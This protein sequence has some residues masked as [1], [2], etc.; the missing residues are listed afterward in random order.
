MASDSSAPLAPGETPVTEDIL[1]LIGPI[2]IGALFSWLLYGVSC[3]QLY[4][5]HVSTYN[6][7]TWIQ[8]S[9]YIIFVMDSLQTVV[10]AFMGWGYLCSGWGHMSALT[11]PGWTFVAIPMISS[12][13][14]AWVQIFYAWR[15]HILKRWR[16]IPAVIVLLALTQC[17][18]GLSTAIGVI[19]FT[20][21][22]QIHVLEANIDVWL[23]GSAAVDT[24]ISVSMVYLLYSARRNP[25]VSA[26]GEKTVNRLIRLSVETGIATTTT[27]VLELGMFFWTPNA[28]FYV[29]LSLI[30]CKVY[31]NALMTSL[32]SRALAS[33]SR[34]FFGA[35]TSLGSSY[36]TRATLIHPT[37][38][39]ETITIPPAVVHVASH[40]EVFRSFN[41]EFKRVQSYEVQKAQDCEMGSLRDQT[42]MQGT[43]GRPHTAPSTDATPAS[44]SRTVLVNATPAGE[45]LGERPSEHIIGALHLRGAHSDRPRVKWDEGVIDNEGMEK[46]KSKICCIY[47]KPKQ[48]D[49]S[50]DESSSDEDDSD[51]DLSGARPSRAL[52]DSDDDRNAYESIP[53]QKKGKERA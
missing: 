19:P 46:K 3:V 30:L 41:N 21:V 35:E 40:T 9:V 52:D 4:L 53:H 18:A 26:R 36:G 48:F 45:R 37:R 14:A 23:A 22:S 51:S 28:N 13:V 11:F 33:R 16:V 44:G 2:F 20:N 38:H 27:A 34:P 49:E 6:D 29:F 39:V 50:S 12:A 43:E 32:N 5:Y 24:V 10:S 8:V 31:S 42:S 1:L 17:A 47:H 7:R 15:I 25:L